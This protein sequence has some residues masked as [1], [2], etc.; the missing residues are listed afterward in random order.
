MM[1]GGGC[2]GVRLATFHIISV[3]WMTISLADQSGL[4]LHCSN[5]SSSSSIG[6]FLNCK[7]EMQ[8]EQ[9]IEIAKKQQKHQ[10]S[11]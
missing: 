8:N 2:V 3:K 10:Q 4:I 1:L 9:Q 11:D 6:V 7:K 5:S